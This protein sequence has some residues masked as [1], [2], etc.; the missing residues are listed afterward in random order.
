MPGFDF[1]LNEF[2]QQCSSSRSWRALSD[3]HLCSSKRPSHT[4]KKLK[5]LKKN[6]KNDR[7][8]CKTCRDL[9]HGALQPG[10]T[11]LQIDLDELY[12]MDILWGLSVHLLTHRIANLCIIHFFFN[13]SLRYSLKS[14]IEHQDILLLIDLGKFYQM[15]ILSLKPHLSTAKNMLKGS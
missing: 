9:L 12:L 5:I 11:P 7:K 2:A 3:G 15:H 6:S 8:I 1:F 13:W 14:A 10:D 4:S